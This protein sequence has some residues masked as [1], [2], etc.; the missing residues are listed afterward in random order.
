M[1]ELKIL[2]EKYATQLVEAGCQDVI[3]GDVIKISDI[4]LMIISCI[5]VLHVFL[6]FVF[7]VFCILCIWIVHVSCIWCIL[8][9]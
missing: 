7:C 3:I 4:Y 6:I 5:Y 9:I 8:C 1:K 2:A